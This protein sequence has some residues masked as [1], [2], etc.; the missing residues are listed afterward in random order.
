MYAFVHDGKAY[1]PDGVIKDTEGTPLAAD[2]ADAYNR[3][4]ERQE[5]DWLKT[6]PDRVFLYVRHGQSQTSGVTT[7]LGTDVATEVQIGRRVNVGFGRH[8]YRR[9]VVCRIFGVRYVGWYLESSGSYC[10][11]RKAKRQ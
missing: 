5:I 9:S 11:L 2:D 10:R 4:V 1:G 7:W 3:E 6:G 8:T